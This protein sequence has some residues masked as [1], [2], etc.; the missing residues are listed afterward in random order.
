MKELEIKRYPLLLVHLVASVAVLGSFFIYIA[1]LPFLILSRWSQRAWRISG[2]ITQLGLM[3]L[4]WFQPWWRGELDVNLPTK[5]ERGEQGCLCVANHRS[6]LDVF[7][8][9]EQI[10]NVRILT[11]HVIF[12]VPGLGCAAYLLRMIRIKRGNQQSFWRAMDRIEIALQNNEVVHVFPEMT[13][14]RFGQRVLNRFTLAPFQKAINTGVPVL[15]IAIWGT[16]FL[17]PKSV[18]GIAAKG[19]LVVRSLETVD[20]KDFS[21]AAD[22]AQH[23]RMQIQNELDRLQKVY[24][25]GEGC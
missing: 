1:N 10:R 2:R 20:S 19:P 15:P 3:S 12:L 16:D 18:Y 25:Y 4:R 9:L 21:T 24:P 6:H 11:K 8:L 14:A 23:V 22:L 5:V 7:L 17:W 13:R